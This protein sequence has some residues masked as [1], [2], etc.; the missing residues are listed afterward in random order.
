M[1]THKQESLPGQ[2]RSQLD[3]AE[4]MV[5]IQEWEVAIPSQSAGCE[6]PYRERASN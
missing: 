2:R 4:V 3:D 6:I 1:T 5:V